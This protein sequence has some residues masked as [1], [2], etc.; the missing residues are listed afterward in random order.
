MSTDATAGPAPSND[1]KGDGVSDG[2]AKTANKS[3]AT[4]NSKLSPPTKMWKAVDRSRYARHV[5]LQEPVTR[6]FAKNARF[7]AQ[8]TLSSPLL[9]S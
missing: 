1:S 5:A 6:A 7:D 8:L 2:D 4:S 3:P 9:G